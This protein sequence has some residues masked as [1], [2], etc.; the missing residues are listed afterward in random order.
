M[1][2]LLTMFKSNGAAHARLLAG[3]I[4][5]VMVL[6]MMV[7]PLPPWLLDA[8]ISLFTSVA[9][10]RQQ[11]PVGARVHGI[12]TDGGRAANIIPGRAAASFMLRARDQETYERIKARFEDLVRAAALAADCTS[13][14]TFSGASTAM[15]DN[16]VLVGLWAANMRALGIED[17]DPVPELA[18]SS[19]MGNVS[20]DGKTLW[21]SGRYD[22]VVYAIDT[23]SGN[24]V[25]IPVGAEPHGLTVWPQPGRYSLGHTGNMR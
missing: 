4:L 6:G 14:V 13:E 25:K 10:W 12:I 15:R 22:D 9:L 5:I 7:L 1:S 19:D 8:M 24:V 18:G 21:L 17:G 2:A 20:N 23:T 3:P 11:L 16:E